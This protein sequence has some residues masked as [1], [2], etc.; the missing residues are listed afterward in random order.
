MPAEIKDITVQEIDDFI[1]KNDLSQK[2]KLMFRIMRNSHI[3][4][5]KTTAHIKDDNLHSPK[6]LLVR[7][8]VIG[9]LLFLMI[10]V[11]TVVAYLPEKIAMLSP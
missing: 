11:S 1:N 3:N 4:G 10:L 9:W 2:D 8:K 5:E 7:T 6:G